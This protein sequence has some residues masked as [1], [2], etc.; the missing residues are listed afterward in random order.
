MRVYQRRLRRQSIPLFSCIALLVVVIIG[1]AMNMQQQK[2]SI[3]PRAY[4]ALLGLIGRVESNNNYNAY[5]GNA[6]N[7]EVKFT[8]MTIAEVMKW[9]ADFVA[10]GHDSSAVGRYQIIDSTLASLVRQLDINTTEK[11]D[12]SIQ[13]Q[14]AIAL[15]ERRG[16]HSYAAEELSPQEFAANLAREWAALPRVIGDDPN[17]SYYAG[18]GINASRTNVDEV[19]KAIEPISTK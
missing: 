4:A 7:Q 14:M 16:S 9:Q 18:D 3:D 13:D 11:F 17:S 10:Q 15:L 6:D 2:P 12:A 1:Y 19:L 5:Y 8:D